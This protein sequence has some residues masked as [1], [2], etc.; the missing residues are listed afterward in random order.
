MRRAALLSILV[1]VGG[2]CTTR[3]SAEDSPP[4]TSGAPAVTAPVTTDDPAVQCVSTDPGWNPI[5]VHRAVNCPDGTPVTVSGVVI[6][7]PDGAR[8]LCDSS[9]V[10]ENCLTLVGVSPAPYPPTISS[11]VVF[12]GVIFGHR[13]ISASRP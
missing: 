13:L 12:T 1:V 11:E 9:I 8:L 3:I 5:S 2:A 10:D 7:Q 4:S 6:A